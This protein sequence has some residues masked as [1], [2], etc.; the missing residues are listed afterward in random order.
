MVYAND[1]ENEIR[2]Q[3]TRVQLTYLA[4][5]DLPPGSASTAWE[6][7]QGK[8]GIP[9]WNEQPDNQADRLYKAKAE[10][11]PAVEGFLAAEPR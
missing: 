5:A 8:D 6:T 4:M 1:I 11:A 7:L 10:D 3:S 9:R 2:A